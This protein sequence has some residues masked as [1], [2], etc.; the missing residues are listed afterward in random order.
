MT[1]DKLTITI[2]GA[3]NI[4][5][6]LGRK[7]HDTGHKVI[8]GVT[9][10]EGKHGTELRSEL[11]ESVIVATA[12]EALAHEADVV[13]M[14]LPG[15]AMESSIITHAAQLD[16]K[17]II[18]TANRLGS[19]PM[20][21]LATFQQHTPR[22]Q[23]YR[24]FNTLGWENFADPLFDGI[25]ADLFYCGPE[26]EPQKIAEQL[27]SDVGLRPVYLGGVEQTSLVDSLGS[28]WFALVFGQHKSRHLAF[29]MLT[30]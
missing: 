22:S 7:W 15:T 3:G 12:S 6:T 4:G 20:N 14:A 29:K 25:Q 8:F 19:G 16:G 2:L 21:S 24:A 17:I 9:N 28:L 5:G 10:P 23:I 13:V 26:G 1:T 11:G 18:D 27:I 30:R